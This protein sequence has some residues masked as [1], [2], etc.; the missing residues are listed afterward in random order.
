MYRGPKNP[1][2]EALA[3]QEAAQTL[4]SHV[5]QFRPCYERGLKRN[6]NLQFI[7]QV[8][9]QLTVTPDGHAKDVQ[10]SPRTDPDMESCMS[11]TIGRWRLSPYKGQ[12]VVLEVPVNLRAQG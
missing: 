1:A 11:Q 4:R 12:P 3:A 2:A 8:K 7:T 9:V 5:S 10:I 6:A